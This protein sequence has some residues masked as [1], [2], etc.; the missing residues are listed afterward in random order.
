MIDLFTYVSWM[1]ANYK[2][3][4]LQLV[5]LPSSNNSEMLDVIFGTSFVTK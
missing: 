2:D 1:V 4:D 5:F 3:S